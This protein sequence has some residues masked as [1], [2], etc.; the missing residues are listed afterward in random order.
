MMMTPK[1]AERNSTVMNELMIENQ[2]ISVSDMWRYVSQREAQAI[3]LTSKRTPYE[4]MTGCFWASRFFSSESGASSANGFGI[5]EPL[6]E[7]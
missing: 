4:K 3:S 2:W 7:T 1:I 6:V 5:A